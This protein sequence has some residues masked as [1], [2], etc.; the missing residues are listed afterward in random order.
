MRGNMK[1]TF[2]ELVKHY[3]T[4]TF[5]ADVDFAAAREMIENAKKLSPVAQAEFADRF[6]L[7]IA[8]D[9]EIY[10]SGKHLAKNLQA[11]AMSAGIKLVIR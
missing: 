10:L 4:E 9:G 6:D 2:A 1:M 8:Y 3:N 7:A 11:E 5:L